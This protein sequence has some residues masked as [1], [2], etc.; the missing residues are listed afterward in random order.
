[1]AIEAEYGAVVKLWDELEI[2]LSEERF[3]RSLSLD[4][5]FTSSSSRDVDMFFRNLMQII[6]LLCTLR[7]RVAFRNMK[8]R[9]QIKTHQKNVAFK[10][11]FFR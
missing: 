7:E 8:N 4:T 3:D 2:D 6:S 10:D 1:M 9:L 5:F 11:G